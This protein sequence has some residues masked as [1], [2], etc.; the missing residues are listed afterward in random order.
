MG[1]LRVKGLVFDMYGTL[2]DVGAVA[3][4]CKEVAPEPVAFNTH[5]RAKQ[6]EYTFLRTLMGKY[7]DF[8]KVTEEALEFTI[9]HFGLQVSPEQRKQ[10]METW[11]HPTPYPEVQAALPRLKEKYLLAALSNGSRNMLQKGLEQTGLR[12]HFRWVM[13]ADAVKLYKPSPGLYRLAL[14]HMRLQKKEILFVSSNSFDVMGSKNFGFKVCWINRRGV[15][16]DPLGAKPELVVKSFDE[17]A[18][19]M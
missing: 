18:E 1:R 10:L 9:Q 11:L 12:S 2:V 8:W 19:N 7:R 6:L 14:K 16:L 5:W 15:P 17:L 3:E 4:A 13:S